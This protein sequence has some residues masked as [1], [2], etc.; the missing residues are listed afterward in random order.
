MDLQVALY[1]MCFAREHHMGF[2]GIAEIFLRDVLDRRLRVTAQCIAHVDLL[3]GYG[4][5]HSRILTGSNHATILAF[6][7]LPV[8]RSARP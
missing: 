5:V 8:V 3:A 2:E 6:N 1:E 4:D 7:G